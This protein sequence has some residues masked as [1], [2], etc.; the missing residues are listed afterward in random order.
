ME[1]L[2]RT[3]LL[4]TLVIHNALKMEKIC[5]KVCLHY[6]LKRLKSKRL[7]DEPLCLNQRF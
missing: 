2:V 3:V 7:C 1:Q 6:Y 4:I 5:L